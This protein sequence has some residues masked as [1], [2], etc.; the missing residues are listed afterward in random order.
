MSIKPQI[1]RLYVIGAGASCPYGF[2]TLKQLTW[3]LCA[4]L[5]EPDRETIRQAI[6]ECFGIELGGPE[7]SPRCDF[8]ELL[9]R[10]EP[11]GLHYV[12]Q[13]SHKDSENVPASA[14]DIALRGLREFLHHKCASVATKEGPYDRLVRTLGEGEAIVSFNWDVLPEIAFNRNHREFAYI[15]DWRDDYPGELPHPDYSNL[16]FLLKPHG[17]I[18]WYALLDWELLI[19]DAAT[20]W[21]TIGKSLAN[22]MLYL[23]DPLGSKD[24]G[25]SSYFLSSAI[26]PVPA[27][28]PPHAAK[29]LSVGGYPSD[30][31]VDSG[32]ERVMTKTW[33]MFREFVSSAEELVIIGYSLPGTD[34]ASIFVLKQFAPTAALQRRKSVAIVDV[35]PEV[36]QRYRRLVH[37]SA[38]LVCADFD[39]FNSTSLSRSRGPEL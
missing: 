33:A 10:L 24:V 14:F 35:N 20:N 16:T 25:Q 3:E 29:L 17:S 26:A 37:P 15:E 22:Y 28:V 6:Y 36:V 8:E 1:K 18:N 19:L 32:H 30:G 31:F 27:I 13:P 12:Q 4:F 5:D 23:L 9:N 21:R 38:S 7:D 39:S 2:P 11:S 34:A